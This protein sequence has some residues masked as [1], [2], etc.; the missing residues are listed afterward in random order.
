MR[1]GQFYWPIRYLLFCVRLHS[2]FSVA[3]LNSLPHL[4]PSLTW[5]FKYIQIPFHQWS[6]CN[7]FF[8]DYKQYRFHKCNLKHGTRQWNCLLRRCQKLSVVSE[9]ED[10]PTVV[11]PTM[12]GSSHWTVR[13][14]STKSKYISPADLL[15][16]RWRRGH[17]DGFTRWV[18]WAKQSGRKSELRLPW[19]MCHRG[20]ALC[21]LLQK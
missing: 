16:S 19:P 17:L 2:L 3:G 14:L 5:P 10:T 8:K 1:K 11:L 12:V 21:S 6:L 4:P 9:A 15:L 20:F 18:F 13:A 7:T